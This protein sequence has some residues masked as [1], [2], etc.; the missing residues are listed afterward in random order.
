MS[1]TVYERSGTETAAMRIMA[2]SGKRKPSQ[3]CYSRVGGQ[4]VHWKVV[5]GIELKSWY[6]LSKEKD[7]SLR[8]LVTP[9]ACHPA[10]LV[11][12]VP[13][14]LSAVVSGTPRVFAPWVDLARYVAKYRNHYWEFVRG[15][16]DDAAK[17]QVRLATGDITYHPPARDTFNDQAVHDDGGNF[18][19]IGRTDLLD[20]Y[21]SITF[22]EEILGAP[23]WL[24]VEF[25]K[26]VGKVSTP[27][28]TAK[29]LA[30]LRKKLPEPRPG[31]TEFAE[32]VIAAIR[33]EFGL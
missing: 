30:A 10:D 19:R 2:S 25:F 7:P 29:S 24:W 33:E 3:T 9:A 23:C 31:D 1:L 5:F 4:T 15:T 14:Y 28:A 26:F 6:V 22:A 13:W 11:A 8:M 18:G 32:A 12:V 20:T 17:R 27:V 21:K 16:E